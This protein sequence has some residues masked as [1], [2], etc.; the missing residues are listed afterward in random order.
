[1]R[2]RD[3]ELGDV[4]AYVQMRCDPVMMAGLGGPLPREGI[5]DKVARDVQAAAAGEA[6]IKMIIPGRPHRTW[7]RGRSRCGPMT[8]MAVSRLPRSAGWS[9]RSQDAGS[10]SGP[11]GCSWSWPAMTAGLC[12]V[13]RD[14]RPW[15]GPGGQASPTCTGWWS[16]WSLSLLGAGLDL[17]SGSC[18]IS[19]DWALHLAGVRQIRSAPRTPGGNSV[20]ARRMPARSRRHW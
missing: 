8:R 20:Q 4:S 16:G 15:P 11:S 9:C 7:W 1:M 13:Q 5:E 14:G 12:P 6:W 2:L 18:C 3:V 19:R 17:R 10:P